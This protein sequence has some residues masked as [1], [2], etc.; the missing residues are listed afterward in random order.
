MSHLTKI[1][2]SLESVAA[3]CE[4]L[5]LLSDPV[6]K[7]LFDI[8]L[9]V[10]GLLVLSPL[11]ALI[12]MSIRIEDGAPVLLRQR[13]AGRGGRLFNLFKFRTMRESAEGVGVIEDRQRDLRVTGVGRVLRATALDELPQLFNIL[14]GDMSFVGP[15]ALPLLIEDEESARYRSIQ[16]VEGYTLRSMI[17]P[18][19]TGVAQIFARKDLPRR[20]KFRYDLLYIKKWNFA[21]DL[22]L[23]ALSVWITVHGRWESR[24]K[25][26]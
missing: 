21:L 12:A 8:G 17:R 11:W 16:E 19:L 3:A 10:F 1:S 25:K 22:R 13:R 9:C 18:G 26:V 7:R 24:G 20:Q 5:S 23:I 2:V 15:R 14:K 6:P 4:P